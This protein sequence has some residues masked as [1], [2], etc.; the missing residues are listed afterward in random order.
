MHPTHFARTA[1]KDFPRTRRDVC[2][3]VRFFSLIQPTFLI[4][5]THRFTQEHRIYK[6]SPT[7]TKKHRRRSIVVVESNQHFSRT[8]AFVHTVHFLFMLG[9]LLYASTT[10]S[11]SN[12]LCIMICL[13]VFGVLVNQLQ[14][15]QRRSTTQSSASLCIFMLWEHLM[16][17]DG[18]STTTTTKSITTTTT[19]TTSTIMYIHTHTH[20]KPGSRHSFLHL[21]SRAEISHC[22]YLGF[23]RRRMFHKCVDCVFDFSYAPPALWIALRWLVLRLRNDL[24]N[25]N[26]YASIR[27]YHSSLRLLVSDDLVIV[28]RGAGWFRCTLAHRC[29]KAVHQKNHGTVLSGSTPETHEVVQKTTHTQCFFFH[30]EYV[31]VFRFVCVRERVRLR[32][33]SCSCTKGSR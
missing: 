17:N 11:T 32:I 10:T 27:T 4:H 8:I 2:T 31:G 20:N 3:C 33:I 30:S 18:R 9:D 14:K 13:H 24:K 26:L 12:A 28:L 22:F 1:H 21:R 19:A 15:Q 29:L 7:H 16:V 25:A 23:S 5:N 6:Y